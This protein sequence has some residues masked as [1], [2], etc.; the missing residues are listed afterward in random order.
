MGGRDCIVVSRQTWSVELPAG[1]CISSCESVC[2]PLAQ[3]DAKD[4]VKLQHDQ[5]TDAGE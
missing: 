3:Y 4:D 5:E 2:T 1:D